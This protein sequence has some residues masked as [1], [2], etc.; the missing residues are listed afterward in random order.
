MSCH[1]DAC[2]VMFESNLESRTDITIW[3]QLYIYNKCHTFSENKH[4]PFLH[5][6][7]IARWTGLSWLLSECATLP[8]DKMTRYC[9]RWSLCHDTVPSDHYVTI[10]SPGDHYVTILSPVIIMSRYCP[11]WS[12]CHDTVPSDHYVT[13]L[14]PVIIMSR[15]CPRWSLC[16][17]TV[18][19]WSLCHDNVPGDH[20]VTMLSPVIIMSRYCS[21]VITMVI[22]DYFRK[23]FKQ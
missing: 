9:P 4:L 14:S 8:H 18:P 20:N 22:I 7:M 19:R 13:I 23:Q 5:Y 2:H 10:L 16:H 21:P 1:G 3:R 15:Y 12:L 17:D 6:S 11:R